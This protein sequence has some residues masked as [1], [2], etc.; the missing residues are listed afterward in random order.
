MRRVNIVIAICVHLTCQ[1]IKLSDS[2]AT[3]TP[4]VVKTP[5]GSVVRACWYFD[6]M[7]EGDIYACSVLA[8][9]AHPNANFKEPASRTY[10][11]HAYAWYVSEGGEN[12][13]MGYLDPSAED[14][15]WTDGSYFEV[16][17]ED[18]NGWVVAEKVGYP[19]GNH[20]AVTTTVVGT[21][22]SKWGAW[23]L[24]EHSKADCPYNSTGLKY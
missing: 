10:N 7:T 16:T 9:T 13:W 24:M 1:G 11:C 20:S 22:K 17:S 21:Y 3:D 12:V 18:V 15:Y 6:E 4:A 23:P 19:N 5:K 14:V 2:Q 8:V